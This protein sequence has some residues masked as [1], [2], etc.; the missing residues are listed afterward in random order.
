MPPHIQQRFNE[1]V[2]KRQAETLTPEELQE[3]LQLTDQIETSDAQRVQ[4]LGE[5]ARL[6]GISLPDLMK[7][8]GIHPARYA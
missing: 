4:Y 8:L 7:E 2:A 6:R 1:L 5:L 3:L